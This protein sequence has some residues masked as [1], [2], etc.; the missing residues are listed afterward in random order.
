[1]PG[2]N[3]STRRKITKLAAQSHTSGGI[4]RWDIPKVG[5]IAR[6]W[7]DIR[8]TINTVAAV[9]AAGQATIFSRF[10]L[11]SNSGID[12]INFS[13]IGFNY[14]LRPYLDFPGDPFPQSTAR[15]AVAGGAIN[16]ATM[17]PVAV[18][19]RDAVGLLMAQ[20]DQTLLTL[21]VQC[22]VD[23]V[24]GVTAWTTN[25]VVRPY[26]E[27]F[28]VP[29]DRA[30]WPN[31]AVVH[32][33]LEDSTAITGTG[34]YTYQ[35]PR[36]NT[37]MQVIH[38]L[39]VAVAGADGFTNAQLRVNQSDY[40]QDTEPNFLDVSNPFLRYQQRLP[41]VIPFDLMS[42]TGLGVYDSM[43]DTID[44]RSVTDL[45]TVIQVSTIGTLYTVRRQLVPLG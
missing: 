24:P 11:I 23:T 26:I 3:S 41:G 42:T 1:M 21:E 35:W 8:G 44:S 30:N 15:S 40:I 9:N 27:Y 31:L 38:G 32:Q 19:A 18:N 16:L 43:R 28:T 12:V 14:L 17:M 5:L 6:V 25:P 7:F 13:G 22:A 34:A 33:I 10:R 37:Y 2:F 45:A 39:G 4:L 29:A 36:G 20:N